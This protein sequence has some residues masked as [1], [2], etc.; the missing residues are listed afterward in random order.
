M[1]EHQPGRIL[2]HIRFQA[3]GNVTEKKAPFA[4]MQIQRGTRCNLNFRKCAKIVVVT[5][6]TKKLSIACNLYVCAEKVFGLWTV[7]N[8]RHMRASAIRICLRHRDGGMQDFQIAYAVGM[9]LRCASGQKI[10]TI[11]IVALMDTLPAQERFTAPV[12][13]KTYSTG[14]M[15][16]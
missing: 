13:G 6:N 2:S 16:C 12:Q 15:R 4:A 10:R 11:D 8:D 3:F 7:V 5:C 14:T 1:A 9:P